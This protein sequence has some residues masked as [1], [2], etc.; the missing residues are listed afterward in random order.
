ML[1]LFETYLL[2]RYLH[3]G[4]T[5]AGIDKTMINAALSEK[6]IAECR[7]AEREFFRFVRN[8][9]AKVALVQHLS[10]P[11]LTGKYQ[12]GYYA[13]QEVAREENVPYVDDADEL[14]TQ[15]K[16]AES[17]FYK[18][19]PLHLGVAGQAIL[20]HALRRGVDLAD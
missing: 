6:D 4:E 13:N 8:H 3:I 10:L 11:E 15:L 12:P 1:D 17:P 18:G 5:P 2:P 19:D 14:Q 7:D 9:K 16:S 20:A